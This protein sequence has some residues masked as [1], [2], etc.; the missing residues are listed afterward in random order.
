MA[1]MMFLVAFVA[2]KKKLGSFNVPQCFSYHTFQQPLVQKNIKY[3]IF[4]TLMP[5]TFHV[6]FLVP[7]VVKEMSSPKSCVKAI[8]KGLLDSTFQC[9]K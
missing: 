9:L 4:L 1:P 2:F 7:L 5:T 3:K 8:L 6:Y